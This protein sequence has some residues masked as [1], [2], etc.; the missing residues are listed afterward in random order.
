MYLYSID[1][2]NYGNVALSTD[3]GGFI[4]FISPRFGVNGAAALGEEKHD[5]LSRQYRREQ[6]K[7]QANGV[8]YDV[9]IRTYQHFRFDKWDNHYTG[10]E[11]NM[12]RALAT[13]TVAKS[14][15]LNYRNMDF[16]NTKSLGLTGQSYDAMELTDGILK[17]WTNQPFNLDGKGAF[18]WGEWRAAAFAAF[19]FLVLLS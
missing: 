18:I 17:A 2:M 15:N 8:R 19:L 1:K 3:R 11:N 6:V 7:A 5:E 13:A 4:D 10:N 14:Q 9:P 16:S 12:W